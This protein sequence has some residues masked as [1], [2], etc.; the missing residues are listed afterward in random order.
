MSHIRPD[1]AYLVLE[2]HM[3]FDHSGYPPPEK[4]YETHSH[5]NII[6]VAD[7]YDALTTMRSYQKARYPHQSLEIMTKLGG[8]SLD[9]YLVSVFAKTLGVY[10]VGTMVRLNTMEIALVVGQGSTDEDAPKVMV[11]LDRNGNPL[12]RPEQVDLNDPEGTDSDRRRSIVATV[13]PNLY[14]SVAAE[15]LYLTLETA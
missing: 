8:K 3:R 11:L 6:P 15:S 1:S 14:S 2:H 13:N 9:P 5:S 10:P 4:G 7:C 12:P